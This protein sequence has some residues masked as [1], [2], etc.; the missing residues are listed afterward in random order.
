MVLI[1]LS[2]LKKLYNILEVLETVPI[3]YFIS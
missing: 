3:K 2:S 1:K